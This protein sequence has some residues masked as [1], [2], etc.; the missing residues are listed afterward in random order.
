MKHVRI[1]LPETLADEA[2]RAGL[3]APER[4]EAML[5]QE[6]KQQ[7]IDAMFEAMEKA[8]GVKD[9]AVLGPEEVAREIAAMRAER[10]ASAN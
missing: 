6:L 1:T 2:K 3:F 10:R 7:R 8:A 4:L 9:E 5:R